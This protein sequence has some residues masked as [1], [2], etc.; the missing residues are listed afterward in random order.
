[1]TMS[2]QNRSAAVMQ[3]R[4]EPHDSLDNFP[5]P[6]WA[7]RAICEIIARRSPERL[8]KLSVREPCA[9]VGHMVKPLREYFGEVIASDIFDYGAGF[10]VRDYLFGDF[11]VT[12]W[13]FL[14]PPFRLAEEFIRKAIGISRHGVAAIVRT[15]FLE[16][17]ERYRDLFADTPPTRMFQ[18]CERVVM[19]KGKLR[20]PNSLYI[21]SQGVL[22]KASS[23][24]SYIWLVWD[25]AAPRQ[26]FD[27]IPVC[28]KRLERPGDY[29]PED[30]P[31]LPAGARGVDLLTALE[32]EAE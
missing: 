12:D 28:R 9:N 14:N 22:R 24:T 2:G 20:I 7:T 3:Q 27:W 10:E 11:D 15:S 32:G 29:P 16:G 1:M 17:D 23:A 21:D 13:T 25:R 19:H 30:N 6:P 31:P 5:T 8:G 4:S 18:H 26:P